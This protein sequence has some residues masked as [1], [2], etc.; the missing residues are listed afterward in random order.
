MVIHVYDRQDE[1]IFTVT[2]KSMQLV[3]SDD[4]KEMPT[5]GR[6]FS[7]Q[8]LGVFHHISTLLNPKLAFSKW[9]TLSIAPTP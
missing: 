3:C 4:E 9:P 6:Y 5:T 1:M 7:Q 8:L 2:M